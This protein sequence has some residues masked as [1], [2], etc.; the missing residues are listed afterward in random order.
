MFCFN[1]VEIGDRGWDL[2]WRLPFLQHRRQCTR[3]SARYHIFGALTKLTLWWP[4]RIWLPSPTPPP[5]PHQH[6][7]LYRIALVWAKACHP[8]PLAGVAFSQCPTGIEDADAG[9]KAEINGKFLEN[10]FRASNDGGLSPTTASDGPPIPLLFAHLQTLLAGTSLQLA[11]AAQQ[12][13]KGMDENTRL[14]LQEELLGFFA[15]CLK[16]HG[17]LMAPLVCQ[18]GM[19]G[20]VCQYAVRPAGEGAPM[21]RAVLQLPCAVPCAVTV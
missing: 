19:I 4:T 18:H 16:H 7:P 12:R 10:F 8:V 17:A 14:G 20:L 3:F 11:G 2:P 21:V 5:N 6:M 1:H 15:F 9:A 13:L